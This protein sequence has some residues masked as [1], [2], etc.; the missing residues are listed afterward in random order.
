MRERDWELS[1]LIPIYKQKGDPLNYGSYQMIKLLKHGMKVLEGFGEKTKSESDY[2]KN[3]IW[4]Y[5]C[6]RDE[7]SNVHGVGATREISG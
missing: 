5:V 2:R 6:E 1:T 7:W 4:I 3:I